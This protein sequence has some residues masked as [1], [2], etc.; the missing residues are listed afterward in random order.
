MSQIILL[1]GFCLGLLHLKLADALQRVVTLGF[2]FRDGVLCRIVSILGFLLLLLSLGQQIQALPDHSVH[3]GCDEGILVHE[4]L[5]VGLHQLRAAVQQ[6]VDEVCQIAVFD[7]LVEQ[8]AGIYNLSVVVNGSEE[9]V[10]RFLLQLA[11][12]NHGIQRLGVGHAVV[13]TVLVPQLGIQLTGKALTEELCDAAALDFLAAKGVP[14]GAFQIVHRIEPCQSGILS[15]NSRRPVIDPAED[16]ITGLSGQHPQEELL[17]AEGQIIRAV[18]AA[19]G[20]IPCRGGS[21]LV[22]VA[23]IDQVLTQVAFRGRLALLVALLSI[24]EDV[25]RLLDHQS[26]RL[27]DVYIHPAAGA[28]DVTTG[29]QRQGRVVRRIAAHILGIT[30]IREGDG[31]VQVMPHTAFIGCRSP[32]SLRKVVTR[33]QPDI[34]L[35]CH[36]SVKGQIRS[37]A[38]QGHVGKF[39]GEHRQGLLAFRQAQQACPGIAGFIA[40]D[41][42]IG[43]GVVGAETVFLVVVVLVIHSAIGG[44]H[45]D[46]AS[47]RNGQFPIGN[48]FLLS[49]IVEVVAPDLIQR[50]HDRQDGNAVSAI[51]G[52]IGDI[53]CAALQTRAFHDPVSRPEAAEIAADVHAGTVSTIHLIQ[54]LR[55]RLLQHITI[56]NCTRIFADVEILVVDR[57]VGVPDFLVHRGLQQPDIAQHIRRHRAGGDQ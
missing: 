33:I 10:S 17:I 53:Q 24:D 12:G 43:N 19:G 39:S 3:Q 6:E 5:S 46:G 36:D 22:G 23:L 13:G 16:L 54:I 25:G 30:L 9:L 28:A 8:I 32:V 35:L 56:R 48:A 41:D 38:A 21:H 44:N 18:H 52:N 51:V 34:A 57:V 45:L 7:L 1:P 20:H 42:H 26:Q 49:H 15:V 37:R 4:F 29:A 14:N 11:A 2:G 27:G 50:G 55:Q 47:V 40:A 31:A